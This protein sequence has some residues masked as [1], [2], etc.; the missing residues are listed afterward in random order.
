MWDLP[1]RIPYQPLQ[2]W[3]PHPSLYDIAINL[4]LNSPISLYTS[5]F[6][7]SI[8]WSIE[9]E[10]LLMHYCWYFEHIGE[11]TFGN[12]LSIPTQFLST[13]NI[14][15][16]WALHGHSSWRGIFIW[17]VRGKVVVK[18]GQRNATCYNGDWWLDYLLKI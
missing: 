13:D 14:R 17:I 15:Y 9:L 1:P 12:A 18:N 8:L 16:I 4:L 11:F 5:M 2:G 10:L 3:L 6:I 7:W